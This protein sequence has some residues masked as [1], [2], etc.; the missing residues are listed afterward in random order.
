MSLIR[1]LILVLGCLAL[2][3]CSA[4]RAPAVQTAAPARNAAPVPPATPVAVAVGPVALTLSGNRGSGN[5]LADANGNTLYTFKKDAPD[6]A[7]CSGDCARDWPPLTIAKGVTPRADPGI[8]GNV[9]VIARAD[10]TYQI[11][12]NH[13]PLYRYSGDLNPGEIRGNGLSGLWLVVTLPPIAPAPQPGI[14]AVDWT[15]KGFPVA[16]AT[17]QIALGAGAAITVGPY[18]LQVPANTFGVPV[19]FVVLAGDLV[20]FAR[21]VPAGQMPML[22]LAFNVYDAR[23]NEL[24]D[25]FNYPVTLTIQSEEI[26]AQTNFYDVAPDG[27]LVPDA[28][29]LFVQ[30]GQ[31]VH[32][33]TSPT[34]GWLITVPDALPLPQ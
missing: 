16:L 21:A 28:A 10:N 17:Q 4:A 8:G 14:G 19:K 22:A 7:T 33:L 3:A 30:P 32:P 11:T 29:G 26:L 6:T 23:T 5:I 13:A 25:K 9:G 1:V 34:T 15:A 24:I 20:T 18:K 27:A 31:L 12:Y 2:A